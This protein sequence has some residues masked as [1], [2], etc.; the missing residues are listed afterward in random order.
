MAKLGAGSL[1]KLGECHPDLQ[2]V[3]RR[4][5]ELMPADLDMTV[6]CGWR[7][8]AEQDKAY[9]E[10]KSKLRFP[11]SRHNRVPAEAVDLAPYPIDWNDHAAFTRL[12]TYVL[13][14]AADLG[15]RVSWGGHWRGF[16][17][18]PHYELS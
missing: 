11:E 2:R 7:G 10:G 17:D 3:V 8:K 9:R 16:I 18:L 6:L 12:A 4:A 14:A 13:A 1:A 15:V 5:V